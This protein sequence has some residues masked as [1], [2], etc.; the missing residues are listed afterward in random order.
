M[1]ACR[2]RVVNIFCS[3]Q[4]LKIQMFPQIQAKC[5]TN[6]IILISNY[7]SWDFQVSFEDF[8]LESHNRDPLFQHLSWNQSVLWFSRQHAFDKEPMYY[9]LTGE[10]I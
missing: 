2:V 6:T 9:M 3:K 7:S 1:Y 10:T 5:L 4:E 8:F